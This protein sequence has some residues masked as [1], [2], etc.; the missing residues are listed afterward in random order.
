M[1]QKRT[2]FILALAAVFCAAFV[3]ASVAGAEDMTIKGTVNAEG[4]L[5]ADDGETYAI[6]TDN[7]MGQNLTSAVEKK[8]EVKGT[9]SETEGKKIIEVMSYEVHE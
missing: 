5:V 1:K 6:S 4:Q 3:L 7:E 2:L 8:V 9:V